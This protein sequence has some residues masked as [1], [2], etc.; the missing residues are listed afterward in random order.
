MDFLIQNWWLIVTAIAAVV[1]ATY[2]IY[3]FIN[4]PSQTQ[5][6][7]IKEWLLYAV[8]EAEKQLG[9]GTGKLKLRLVY[10]MFLTQFN[11]LSSIISFEL[12]SQLVDE[13][14]ITFRELLQQNASIADYVGQKEGDK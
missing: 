5:I 9:G 13:V 6:T 3:K 7:K 10:D 14:L 11:S 8:T 2:S 1:V 12:F 4:T